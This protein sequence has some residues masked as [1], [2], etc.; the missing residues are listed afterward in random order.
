[1]I[2]SK[3]AQIKSRENIDEIN[4]QTEKAFEQFGNGMVAQVCE[5]SNEY[6][7]LMGQGMGNIRG[8]D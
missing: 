3:E 7:N 8:C 5:N 1:M 4:K 2:E 6:D